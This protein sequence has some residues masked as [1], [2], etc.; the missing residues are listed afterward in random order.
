MSEITGK[1]VGNPL[2]IN[3]MTG[4]VEV[5]R[6]GP[7]EGCPAVPFER[8]S[9]RSEERMDK[10]LILTSDHRAGNLLKMVLQQEHFFPMLTGTLEESMY[11]I[12]VSRPDMIVIDLP[13]SGM[14]SVELCRQLQACNVK[15]PILILSN[16]NAE[17][18]KV[19]ALEAGADYYLVKPFGLR[20]L[21]ACVHALLRRS[22][23]NLD[24]VIC[25]GNVEVD[26]HRRTVTC[27][28]RTIKMGPCEYKLLLFF[29]SHV[30]L[31]LT[32]HTLLQAVW[33]YSDDTNTRTLDAHVRKLRSKCEPDPNAPRHFVTIHCVGYRFVL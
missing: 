17:I 11:S 12:C 14:S 16:S 15:V 30:G 28:G 21:V 22:K 1:I 2:L 7:A 3:P 10:I 25:F 24:P 32:R 31:V 4:A 26:R 33:G 19:L 5:K 29:L 9:P 13:E 23:L 6:R 18:D 8:E 20:E 27:Y